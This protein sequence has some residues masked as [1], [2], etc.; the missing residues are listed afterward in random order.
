[1]TVTNNTLIE[2][3]NKKQDKQTIYRTL[4][5]IPEWGKSSVE[6]CIRENVI[7]PDNDGSINISHDLLRAIMIIDRK[8]ADFGS[9]D[10]IPEWYRSTIQKLVDMGVLKVEQGE[11]EELRLN[12]NHRM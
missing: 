6:E 10:D 3:I 8:E 5:D 7:V 4:N 9:L 11:N 2:E 1:M 12:I